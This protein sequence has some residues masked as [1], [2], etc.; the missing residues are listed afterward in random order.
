MTI[1]RD[2]IVNAT[3]KGDSDPRL[4]EE[5]K[6]NREMVDMS[7]FRKLRVGVDEMH[8]IDLFDDGNPDN[9]LPM[10]ILSIKEIMDI[11]REVRSWYGELTEIQRTFSLQEKRTAIL[12]LK[13]A[14]SSSDLSEDHHYLMQIDTL[15]KLPYDSL[16]FLMTKYRDMCDKYNPNLEFLTEEEI[17]VLVDEL[18]KKPALMSS[19]SRSRLE[20]VLL[21]I[22]QIENILMDN[23]RTIT[24]P[25]DSI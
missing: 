15:E 19:L 1:S 11:E 3:K 8:L 21:R 20:Q 22:I 7:L 4:S 25:D 16:V 23:L 9:M 6:F 24:S 14:L 2:Q 12:T 5:Q 17:N 10:R 18:K 13:H